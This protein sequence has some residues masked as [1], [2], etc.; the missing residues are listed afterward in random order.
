MPIT[1][2]PTVPRASRFSLLVLLGAILLLAAPEQ[3][4]AG[5]CGP[6]RRLVVGGLFSLTG[7]WSTL[8]ASS[9]AA[10][11]LAAHDV[12]AYLDRID[13][14]LEVEI[15]IED[16][17]LDPQLALKRL[18][19][20][21]AHGVHVVVGPQSSA[22]L[23]AVKPYAD[24]HEILLL[25]QSSTAGSLALAGDN[26][27]RLCPGDDLEGEAI[28]AL[29]V[30]DGV[31][32][33]VPVWRNDAGNS[34]LHD[35]T[36]AHFTSL[37]GTML[38]GVSYPADST[39]FSSVV[40][41]VA[42]QVTSAQAQFGSGAVA[43]YLAAFDEVVGLFHAAEGSSVLRSTRWYGS[44]GVALSNAL[45]NDA[46]AASF[47]ASTSYPN[48]TFGLDKGA[49]TKWAPVAARIE[50][51]TGFKPDAFALG[52]Y[53]AVWLVAQTAVLSRDRI[54]FRSFKAEL[55]EVAGSYYGTTAWTV[56]NDKGDRKFG[57]FDFW[58][59]REVNGTLQ[60]KVVAQY[61]TASGTL[62]KHD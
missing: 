45:L 55:P 50:A 53:D 23:A 22:E 4:T 59:I 34:G 18:K 21:A 19:S 16:T 35:A 10:L 1:K 48:P 49:E 3:G 54:V 8:G 39:D 62:Q 46:A 56:L 15:A 5:Q 2:R 31:R 17:K 30:A 41:T 25:S 57:D 36:Q 44:D 26:V 20:L 29:M 32:A 38:Q 58:A 60:W 51:E 42:A 52:A 11:E 12:N 43:V 28:A 13:S 14:P 7:S 6:R 40:S 24:A 61:S 9:A 47:A 37:G 33:V 27:L